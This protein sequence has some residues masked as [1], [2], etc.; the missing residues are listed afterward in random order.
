MT[1][2]GLPPVIAASLK[3]VFRTVE[4]VSSAIDDL[5][6]SQELVEQLMLPGTSFDAQGNQVD[7]A[8]LV[9]DWVASNEMM[10]RSNRSRKVRI[11][12]QDV[13]LP[14]PAINDP[15]IFFERLS[16]KSLQLARTVCKSRLSK[17]L[18]DLDSSTSKEDIEELERRRWATELSDYIQE[19]NLPVATIISATHSPV[20][21]W[22][23]L[24]GSKR[25]KTLRNR[26]RVWSRVRQWLLQVYSTPFPKGRNRCWIIC[27]Q[28]W[29]PTPRKPSLV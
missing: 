14:T 21:S 8:Q 15:S 1:W 12:L 28:Q 6:T 5:A 13:S 2:H 11:M 17:K 9:L 3:E 10:V 16:A 23:R 20:E 7:T 27:L 19:A 25:A 24:F 22:M 4:N 26:C 18:R 29:R